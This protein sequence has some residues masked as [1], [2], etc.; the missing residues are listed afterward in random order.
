MTNENQ[1]IPMTM[2]NEESQILK[3]DIQS[4]KASLVNFKGNLHQLAYRTL[5]H[6]HSCGDTVYIQELYNA[7]NEDKLLRKSAYAKWILEYAPAVFNEE[8]K[9]FTK[10][11]NPNSG[12]ALYHENQE[13]GATLLSAAYGKRFWDMA[14]G[15]EKVNPSTFDVFAENIQRMIN[16]AKKDM[17][18]GLIE[19][20][21][22]KLVKEIEASL[23]NMLEDVK[24]KTTKELMR[25]VAE[26]ESVKPAA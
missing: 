14:G 16:K 1:S 2:T 6:F 17:E 24:P 20:S 15:E 5:V 23:Q 7:L 26:L 13:V 25:A 18:K 22:I 10:N 8:T 11:K 3:T 9:K 4:F 12:K 21:D 19:T